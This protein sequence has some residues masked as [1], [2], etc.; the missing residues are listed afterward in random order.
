[1]GPVL[2]G[3]FSDPDIV[4]GFSFTT[5]LFVGALLALVCLLSIALFSK[6]PFV[7]HRQ[8]HI[9][10]AQPVTNIIPAYTRP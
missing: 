6:E 9:A 3:V 2:G 4:A 1:M 5:P 8:R 7:P 10:W